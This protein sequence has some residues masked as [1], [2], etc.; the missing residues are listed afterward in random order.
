MVMNMPL[1][2][3]LTKKLDWCQSVSKSWVCPPAF[4][5]CQISEK[6]MPNCLMMMVMVRMRAVSMKVVCRVSVHTTVLMPPRKV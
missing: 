4:I 1:M 5:W 3:C 6:G 2:I